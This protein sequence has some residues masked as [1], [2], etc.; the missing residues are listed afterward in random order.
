MIRNRSRIGAFGLRSQRGVAVSI[1]CLA[2]AISPG[3]IPSASVFAQ[4]PAKTQ[5]QPPTPVSGQGQSGDGAGVQSYM[6]AILLGVAVFAV[7]FIPSKRG[8][9]D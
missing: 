7:S 2:L 4:A 1:A 8:H 5:L 3:W 9:Q 6:V